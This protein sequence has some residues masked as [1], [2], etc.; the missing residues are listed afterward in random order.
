MCTNHTRTFT[1]TTPVTFCTLCPSYG[2]LNARPWISAMLVA[3]TACSEAHCKTKNRLSAQVSMAR[4]GEESKRLLTVTD[5]I[6]HSLS[7]ASWPWRARQLMFQVRGPT[8]ARIRRWLIVSKQCSRDYLA[9][10]FSAV[11]RRSHMAKQDRASLRAEHQEQFTRTRLTAD[12]S[13]KGG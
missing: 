6:L 12:V 13:L 11:Q 8:C 10:R 7:K 5:T 2:D 9:R 4:P 3:N 1:V